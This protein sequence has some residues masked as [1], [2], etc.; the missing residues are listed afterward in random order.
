[1]HP[2]WPVQQA[3][4]AGARRG[5]VWRGTGGPGRERLTVSLPLDAWTWR[6]YSDRRC[7]PLLVS[8]GRRR[9]LR[10]TIEDV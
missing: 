10:R 9:S 3:W 4:G 8:R 7:E 1:M 2:P 5:A 6:G